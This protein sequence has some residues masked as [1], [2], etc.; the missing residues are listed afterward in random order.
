[1]VKLLL[2]LFDY[3]IFFLVELLLLLPLGHALGHSVRGVSCAHLQGRRGLMQ[4]NRVLGILALRMLCASRLYRQH[5]LLRY[6]LDRARPCVAEPAVHYEG[7]R[8]YFWDRSNWTDFR[9]ILDR[10]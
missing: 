2:E 6:P 3:L 9:M 7:L 8:L 4:V 5:V 10:L 1:M